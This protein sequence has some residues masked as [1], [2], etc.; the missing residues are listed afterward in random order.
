MFSRIEKLT[1]RLNHI[2]CGRR[3]YGRLHRLHWRRLDGGGLLA[4]ESEDTL[5]KHAYDNRREEP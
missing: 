2:G 4:G 1:L 3:L 5:R